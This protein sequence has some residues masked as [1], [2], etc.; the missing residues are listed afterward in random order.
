MTRA[1]TPQFLAALQQQVVRPVVLFEGAFGPGA[2]RLWSGLGDLVWNGFTWTGAGTLLWV[3]AIEEPTEIVAAGWSVSLSG[4][5]IDL[6]S[7]VLNDV[8]QGDYGR[9]WIGLLDG[10]GALIPEPALAAS[11]RMDQPEISEDGETCEISVAYEGRLIDLYRPREWRYTH[12]S[13]QQIAPGD[14]AFEYVAALQDKE[15]IWGAASPAGSAV[16]SAQAAVARP[17]ASNRNWTGSNG[18]PIQRVA[19]PSRF[20]D[21]GGRWIGNPDT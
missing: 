5:P 8:Q 10:N 4:V 20:R 7:A 2:I 16:S 6:V 21:S 14:R 15:V 11:G 19:P 1:V 17:A 13:Q 12:E 9:I 3:S 18:T